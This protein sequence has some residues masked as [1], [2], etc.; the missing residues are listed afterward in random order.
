MWCGREHVAIYVNLV[1]GLW[2]K[3]SFQ[4]CLENLEEHNTNATGW[5]VTGKSESC[6]TDIPGVAPIT[7]VHFFFC[8]RSI[9]LCSFDVAQAFPLRSVL[10]ILCRIFSLLIGLACRTPQ[11]LSR[12][13]YSETKKNV[14]LAMSH[15]AKFSR[16]FHIFSSLRVPKCRTPKQIK[17]QENDCAE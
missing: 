9:P 11:I 4:F 17:N 6:S 2:F 5:A 15:A 8:V 7:D 14:T 1:V 12:T 16:L 10:I 3:K 13:S